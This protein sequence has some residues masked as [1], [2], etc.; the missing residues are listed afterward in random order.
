MELS[1]LDPL[2]DPETPKEF[3]FLF[4]PPSLRNVVLKANSNGRPSGLCTKLPIGLSMK[5]KFFDWVQALEHALNQCSSIPSE[6]EVQLLL[7]NS[8]NIDLQ[9]AVLDSCIKHGDYN[10]SLIFWFD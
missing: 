2:L 1:R 4:H 5:S 8:I 10:P 9:S 6:S 7:E 3:W